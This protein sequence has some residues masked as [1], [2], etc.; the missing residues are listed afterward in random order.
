MHVTCQKRKRTK[1]RHSRL[2]S[3]PCALGALALRFVAPHLERTDPATGT[4]QSV[5]STTFRPVATPARPPAEH[6]HARL[7]IMRSGA[8]TR[9]R[10][11]ETTEAS[12]AT[13]PTSSTRCSTSNHVADMQCRGQRAPSRDRRRS[14]AS[15]AD[16]SP[17]LYWNHGAEHIGER[18]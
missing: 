10:W 12:T 15:L 6:P 3:S 16:L 1:L 7:P 11:P 14:A 18:A 8:M 5:G 9:L 2:P 13:Q 4:S 17:A